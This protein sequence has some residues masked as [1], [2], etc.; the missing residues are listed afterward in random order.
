MAL[1][2]KGRKY[3]FTFFYP[4]VQKEAFYYFLSI[5]IEIITHEQQLE[6]H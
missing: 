5:A 6:L 2:N 1:K 4:Y 3:D